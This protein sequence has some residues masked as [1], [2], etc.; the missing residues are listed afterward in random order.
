MFPAFPP[1]EDESDDGEPFSDDE[2]HDQEK[3][4]VS[5]QEQAN[6]VEQEHVV[7]STGTASRRASSRRAAGKRSADEEDIAEVDKQIKIIKTDLDGH[8]DGH[9]DDEVD[10]RILQSVIANGASDVD[11]TVTATV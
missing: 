2:Q 5:H 10:V 8:D 7:T 1:Y 6:E 4:T 3:P 11:Q 9:D